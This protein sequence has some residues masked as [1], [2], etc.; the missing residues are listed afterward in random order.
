MSSLPLSNIFPTVQH[1]I[2]RPEKVGICSECER[3]VGGCA[4]ATTVEH[5]WYYA[6]CNLYFIGVGEVCQQI[7]TSKTGGIE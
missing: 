6:C 2:D 5:Y 1:E 7:H 4:T 3:S